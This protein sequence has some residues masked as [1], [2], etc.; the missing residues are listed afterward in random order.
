MAARR[1]ASLLPDLTDTENREVARI[2][3]M[4]GIDGG[5]SGR[6]P[7]VRVPHHGASMEGNLCPC[8]KL[9]R[10]DTTC[11]CSIQEI[12]RYWRRL[13]GALLDRVEVR[14]RSYYR[15]HSTNTMSQEELKLRVHGAIRRQIAR[16]GDG[17]YLANGLVPPEEIEERLPLSA[18]LR[19][20]LR[21]R[22]KQAG[23]SDRAAAG[24]RSVARTLADLDDRADVEAKDILEATGLRLPGPEQLA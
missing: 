2:Y 9:G 17:R 8:G 10:P 7:P 15:D 22:M 1:I 23:L 5:R 4:R 21:T 12:A 11:M 13:G 3:S 14:V 6:R 19:R 18:G 20:L 16:S 24:V